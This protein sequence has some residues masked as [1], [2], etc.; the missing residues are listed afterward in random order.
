[1]DEDKETGRVIKMYGSD[2]S[3]LRYQIK[4]RGTFEIREAREIT[5]EDFKN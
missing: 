2:Y 4:P 3:P 5:E 1:M